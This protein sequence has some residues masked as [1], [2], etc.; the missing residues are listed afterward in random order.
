M[1]HKVTKK[2]K[3]KI[4]Q[5]ILT[6]PI[7]YTFGLTAFVWHEMPL[8][9]LFLEELEI[10]LAD[11]IDMKKYGD[12]VNKIVVGFVVYPNHL[13]ALA[14]PKEDQEFIA[15]RKIISIAHSANYEALSDATN[16]EAFLLIKN[17]YFEILNE[18]LPTLNISN[19][20][21]TLFLEDLKKV[22]S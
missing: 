1:N 20:N 21:T 9:K 11:S 22:L 7:E 4:I 15:E 10:L 8:T 19:F 17:R 13:Q 3:Q 2:T 12:G 6:P 14:A 18:R 16:K 5:D